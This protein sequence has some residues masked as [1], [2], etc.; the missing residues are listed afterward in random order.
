VLRAG[1]GQY[2]YL[3]E[4]PGVTQMQPGDEEGRR[5]SMTAFG[6]DVGVNVLANLVA[7]AI[8]Y[9]LGVATGLFPKRELAIA[10]S[11]IVAGGS[12]ALLLLVAAAYLSRRNSPKWLPVA[13]AGMLTLGL[14]MALSP[15]LGV[16]ESLLYKIGYLISGLL[17]MALGVMCF[18]IF[19]KPDG[20]TWTR[21]EPS[22]QQGNDHREDRPR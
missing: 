16:G 11:I 14:I 5:S 18:V 6:R 17:A 10:L 3:I 13:G 4:L 12:V 19:R 1:I 8:I 20:L 22:E 2:R 21:P 9:L 15:F 7:A